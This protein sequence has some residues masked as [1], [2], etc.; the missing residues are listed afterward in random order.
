MDHFVCQAIEPSRGEAFKWQDAVMNAVDT[1][2]G[3]P[4]KYRDPA[5]VRRVIVSLCEL[6]EKDGGA[7]GDFRGE[8]DPARAVAIHTHA[9]HAVRMARALLV[10]DAATT[11]AET[12]P[13]VRLIMECG[14]TAAYLLL[15]DGSGSS[16]I[17]KGSDLRRLAL[18]DMVSLGMDAEDSLTEAIAKLAELDLAGVSSGWI[19]QQHCEYLHGG[20]QLYAL[21]RV[22]SSESHAGMR[23]ADLYVIG[24]DHSSIGLAFV[25]DR[26][27]E[28]KVSSLGVA[29]SM[30]FLAINADEI[31]RAN[32]H[33]TTQLR[34]IAGRLG[35][36]TRILRADGS[37]HP[38]R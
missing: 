3:P 2:F 30:L 8:L 13:T 14:V 32:P 11:G 6:W 20:I 27:S 10:L 29:A 15:K 25:A 16:M 38:P 37:E 22:L 1:P 31:A 7:G 17:R 21:Y 23:V 35:V 36:G 26:P 33:R 4:S 9:H 19:F 5:F 24:D 18:R 34:K 28:S 12:V